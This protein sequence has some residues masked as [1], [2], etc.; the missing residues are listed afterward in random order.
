MFSCNCWLNKTKEY[1]KKFQNIQSHPLLSS[2]DIILNNVNDDIVILSYIYKYIGNQLKT[3]LIENHN[4]YIY[5]NYDIEGLLD[6]IDNFYEELTDLA[7]N[8]D[9]TNKS[10]LNLENTEDQSNYDLYNQIYNIYNILN[11]L[12]TD[13][14]DINNAVYIILNNIPLEKENIPSITSD[15]INI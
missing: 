14:S 8:I 1:I 13:M 7:S 2:L 9:D 12:Y 4:E 3:F 11:E 5:A 15:N 6:D 10:L